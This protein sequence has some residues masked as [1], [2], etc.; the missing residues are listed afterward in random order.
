MTLVS[1]C[2]KGQLPEDVTATYADIAFNFTD[3][4]IE[5]LYDRLYNKPVETPTSSMVDSENNALAEKIM[6]EFK[7]G[8]MTEDKA[9]F[10]TQLVPSVEHHYR[11][12]GWTKDY[13][14]TGE[15]FTEIDH[16]LN[17][18]YRKDPSGLW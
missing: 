15:D 11:P 17:C 12:N 18:I 1:A 10:G 13:Y 3:E 8:H 16:I 2:T 5:E 7:A 4:Q 6:N 9:A 14:C